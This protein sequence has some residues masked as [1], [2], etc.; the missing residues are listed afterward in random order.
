MFSPTGYYADF[1]QQQYRRDGSG[2][3][4]DF[5]GNPAPTHVEDLPVVPTTGG[6]AKIL[7]SE[8]KLVTVSAHAKTNRYTSFT[9][10]PVE[11]EG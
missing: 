2:P 3:V 9:V 10:R 4:T 8:G 6:E 7:N 11:D 5:K 1:R